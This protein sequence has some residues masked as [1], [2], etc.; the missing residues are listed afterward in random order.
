M[1][2]RVLPGYPWTGRFNTKAEVTAYVGG[3]WIV[4]LMCGQSKKRVSGA[5]LSAIHD[6]TIEQYKD[7]FNIPWG[8]GLVGTATSAACSESVKRRL[9]TPGARERL[10][11]SAAAAR[12]NMAMHQPVHRPKRDY[13]IRE[14]T[15]QGLRI[16]GREAPYTDADYERV[17]DEIQSGKTLGEALKLPG[18]P[19]HT[20]WVKYCRAHPAFLKRFHAIWDALPFAMQARGQRLGPRF[21]RAVRAAFKAGKNDYQ[22]AADLGVTVMTVNRRTQRW[23]AARTAQSQ[24]A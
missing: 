23:R 7:R 10:L 8:V 13:Q 17:L 20:V 2:R 4:C 19:S 21:T 3:A 5:H 14:Y 15:E 11:A 1:R 12:A 9:K 16:V 24:K 22:I 18:V 6:M